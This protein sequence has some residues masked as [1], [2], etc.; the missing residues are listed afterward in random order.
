VASV[1]YGSLPFSEQIQFFRS[2]LRLP[3]TG[4]TDV[5]AQEH[6]FA[7]MVA[8]ANRDEILTDFQRA[9]DK[10]ISEGATLAEF[11]REFDAIV[12]RYG[13]DY[14][15]G[16]NWRSRVIYDTNLR[17]SY[18]AGRYEQ[19]QRIRRTNPYWMYVHSDAVVHPRPEH[20]SW[21][22]RVI[23]ADDPWWKSHFPPNGWGCQCTVRALSERD[24]RRMNK[25]VSE[26]PPSNER[27]VT[28]GKRS[29]MGP[30]EVRVP[31]GIDPGFE[32]A[33]GRA[34]WHSAIPPE[35]P[36]P[37]ISGSAGGHGLPNRRPPDDLPAPRTVSVD[38]LVS[39]GLTQ[40]QYLDVFL[41]EFGASAHRPIVF[42][43]VIGEPIAIGADL[44]LDVAGTLK[45]TKR[46]REKFLRLLADTIR[47]PDEIWVRL[48]WLGARQQATIR[49]RYVARFVVAGERTP[50]LAVFERGA[51]GWF[52]VTGFAGTSQQDDAWR[53]GVRLYRRG[54]DDDE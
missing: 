23:H 53:V 46:G 30:R 10:A 11:R 14:N 40:E 54:Q 5:Y 27:T 51:D 44:F 6:D 9:I 37:P 38:R 35:K 18:A 34:R 47:A 8:G 41:R 15:G 36:D 4:W 28:I 12:A 16:R 49:R 33:P 39:A 42:R 7:F 45:V 29:A 48:E 17:T 26:A 25:T 32:Y 50:M 22:G 19:L 1:T 52:G 21:D 31:E 20:L 43:D 2:K 24:L 13:W 3:T